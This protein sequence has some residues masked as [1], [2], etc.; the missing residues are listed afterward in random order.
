M[1]EH[2]ADEFGEGDAAVPHCVSCGADLGGPYCHECGERRI[3]EPP[4]LMSIL[5]ESFNG[6][7]SLERGISHTAWGML[8]RPGVTVNEYL[9][10]K[11]RVHCPPVRFYV[12]CLILFLALVH[13]VDLY[14][15]QDWQATFAGVP[16]SQSFFQVDPERLERWYAA[17][18]KW[19]KPNSAVQPLGF[20]VG[21]WIVL[22]S[23]RRTYAE[24]LVFAAYT[25][26][27]TSFVALIL[28]VLQRS[29]GPY[30]SLPFSILPTVYVV[31]AAHRFYRAD[32]AYAWL[33]AIG[34]YLL[35][36]VVTAPLLCGV[37]I[38]TWLDSA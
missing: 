21:A 3:V 22:N 32:N 27:V 24:H 28:V 4:R 5:A 15:P 36:F 1:T 30:W 13:V 37:S 17:M 8:R 16:Q 9:I 31:W 29:L 23:K 25:F 38:W 34:A 20:A 14:L 11:R 18:L 7:L 33:R 2:V 35:M 10:G 19:A 12:T 26:G 6:F